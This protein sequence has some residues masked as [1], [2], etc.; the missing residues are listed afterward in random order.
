[1]KAKQDL[2]FICIFCEIHPL[3][4][5]LLSLHLRLALKEIKWASKKQ[6]NQVRKNKELVTMID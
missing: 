3:L 2:L 4:F 6:N 1:M 5:K